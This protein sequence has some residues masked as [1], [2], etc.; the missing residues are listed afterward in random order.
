MDIRNRQVLMVTASLVLLLASAVLLARHLSAG[1]GSAGES[2]FFYDLST[3]EL[4]AAPRDTMAPFVDPNSGRQGVRAHLYACGDCT[5][6]RRRV[7]YLS[8]LAD[9]A[10]RVFDDPNAASHDKFTAMD[11]GRLV[12]AVPARVG[13]PIEWVPI[14]SSQGLTIT[15]RF[16]ADCPNDVTVRECAP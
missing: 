9:E 6:E 13:D 11:R 15:A 14:R 10:K 12:A 4:Y 7:A 16:G 2:A 8:R 3:G 5:P 1:R